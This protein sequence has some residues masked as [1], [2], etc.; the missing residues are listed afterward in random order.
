MLHFQAALLM[1]LIL[2]TALPV[3]QAGPY[4]VNMESAI[5]CKKFVGFPLPLKALSYFY[6]TSKNCSKHG[7]ILVT[8]K[9]LEICADPRKTWVKHAIVSIKKG[10]E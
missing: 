2:G 9:N 10:K 1:A 7:V 4:G 8:K 6:F 3:T 5:C